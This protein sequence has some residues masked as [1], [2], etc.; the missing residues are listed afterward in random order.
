MGKPSV[1]HHE[2]Q[3]LLDYLQ[4]PYATQKWPQKAA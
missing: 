3:Q 1:V 2:E 4:N